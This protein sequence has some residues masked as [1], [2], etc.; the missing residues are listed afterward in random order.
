MN[1]SN[2]QK[3]TTDTEPQDTL[4]DAFYVNMTLI[5]SAQPSVVTAHI[6]EKL[7]QG[8][9]MAAVEHAKSLEDLQDTEWIYIWMQEYLDVEEAYV[10]VTGL[11]E[12][13]LVYYVIDDVVERYL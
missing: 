5:E 12:Q 3:S 13:Y 2:L 7:E 10:E 8:Y 9:V 1:K 4:A 11:P 6:T